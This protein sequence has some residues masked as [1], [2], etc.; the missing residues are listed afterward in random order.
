M[1]FYARYRIIFRQLLDFHDTDRTRLG[2]TAVG[3]SD[4]LHISDVQSQIEVR[5]G[6]CQTGKNGV[7]KI[8]LA[9]NFYDTMVL[10]I[11]FP[12]PI[13]PQLRLHVG[14]IRRGY[15]IQYCMPADY[16]FW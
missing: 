5:A 15:R 6:K 14:D 1:H 9:W 13:R 11:D 8:F 7:W 2:A 3:A 10:G 16:H 12:I 4:L